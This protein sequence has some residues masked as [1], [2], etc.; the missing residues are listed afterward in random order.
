S[1]PEAAPDDR[2]P[3]VSAPSA[4]A[5]SAPWLRRG[6]LALLLVAMVIFTYQ[7]A[8]D[9]GFIWDDDEYV[10]HNPLI[11]APDGLHR[12]WFSTDS[13][14]QYFPLVY[15]NFRVQHALW[16]FNSVGYHW[17][18]ILLHA[19]NALLLWRLLARLAIPGAWLG[20]AIFALHPLQ[21]ESVA[22]ITELTNVQSRFVGLLVLLLWERFTAPRTDTA[23]APPPAGR[24]AF[25]YLA[26]LVCHA[27]A[28]FSKTTA[29]TLPAGLVLILWIQHRRID[30]RRWLQI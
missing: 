20:A 15:T 25:L 11:T 27:L 21:V 3:A 1:S 5:H 6:L 17:V 8:W 24:L 30:L 19:V 26:A 7:P 14:S 12:I 22:W 16:G 4:S 10:T 23:P 9:A 2:S 29:C 13:P 18:N 28:L